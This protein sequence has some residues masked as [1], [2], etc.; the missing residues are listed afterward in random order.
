MDL[1][2]A[3]ARGFDASARHP[4]ERARLAL[5]Q[6]LLSRH[7]K[8]EPGAPVIDFGCGDTYVVG[9][10]ARA[11]PDQI[12]YAV[13][14]AFT[15]D[16]LSLFESRL[17][18]PNV[19]LFPSLDRVPATRPAAVVLLMDVLEHIEDDR[20][21]LA[22]I[23]RRPLVDAE[24]RVLITV[25]AYQSLFC[26]HD[27]FLGH[28]RRYS[29]AQLRATVS[30]AGLR[31]IVDGRLFAS[32]VPL[33]LLQMARERTF[34]EPPAATTDLA[35]WN[36]GEALARVLSRLLVAEGRMA[37][38]FAERGIMLPGLSNFA[39]CRRSA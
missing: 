30:A 21:V 16:L 12:F 15:D 31:P 33:R 27:R 14:S 37:L 17:T 20:G 25:P 11:Y 13:D 6:Q 38:T 34:G 4:W 29:P 24:T 19:R 36:G 28:Y 18:Q 1:V 9:E 10:L 2:E 23:C 7:A 39:L 26:S 3:R 5:A 22:D 32:L 8:L 35:R